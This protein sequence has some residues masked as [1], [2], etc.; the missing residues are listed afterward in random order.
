MDVGIKVSKG[1]QQA[2]DATL[3]YVVF[4]AGILVEAVPERL[5]GDKPKRC[6]LLLCMSAASYAV[7][8]LQAC[9]VGLH[10]VLG[11]PDQDL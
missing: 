5:L 1:L 4:G 3:I 6:A 10:W 8:P 2:A 9:R 11:L 7:R